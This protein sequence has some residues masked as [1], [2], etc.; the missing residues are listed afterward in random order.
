MEG[1]TLPDTRLLRAELLA[2]TDCESA[3][4]EYDHVVRSG[5]KKKFLERALYGR[6]AL[7]VRCGDA[8]QAMRD[9]AKYLREFPGG[10][11]AKQV[12]RALDETVRNAASET[13]TQ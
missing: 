12:R 1:R 6:G 4:A 5:A 11:H 3:L 10:K 9:F 2:P 13:S 7:G 8:E